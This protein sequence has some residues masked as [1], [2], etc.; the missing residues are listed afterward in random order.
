[1]AG[2]AGNVDHAVDGF[3][4]AGSRLGTATA[5]TLRAEAL[6]HLLGVTEHA[7]AIRSGTLQHLLRISDSAEKLE[8]ETLGEISTHKA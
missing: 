3:G 5:E 2:E 7:S 6:K 4:S 1:M 8:S